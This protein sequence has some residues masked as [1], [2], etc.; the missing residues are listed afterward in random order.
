MTPATLKLIQS[1]VIY[2]FGRDK[3]Y[4]TT[5]I[6]DI[7]KMIS[8]GAQD[9]DAISTENIISTFMFLRSYQKRCM[10]APGQADHWNSIT[11]MGFASATAIPRT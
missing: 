2:V 11:D 3:H 9:E 5:I 4:R 1:G 7:Q 6:N 10:F 8:V